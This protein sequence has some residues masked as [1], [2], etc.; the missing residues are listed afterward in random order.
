MSELAVDG[1][2]ID[3]CATRDGIAIVCPPGGAV[4]TSILS[5]SELRHGVGVPSFKDV[6]T[7]VDLELLAWIRDSR[8]LDTA[9]RI[10]EEAGAASRL[11]VVVDDLLYARVVRNLSKS[12]R[13]VLRISNPY[14]NVSVIARE[15]VNAIAAFANLIRP[16]IVRECSSH[17]LDVFAWLVN[18]VAQAIKAVRYGVKALTT[19]RPTLKKEL[20]YFLSGP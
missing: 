6:L 12:C 1:V 8:A 2:L 16:R 19:S 14:P 3:F 20:Q 10:I 7:S 18:D 9:V 17:G 15:G 4:D 11:Y 5:Y 13:V